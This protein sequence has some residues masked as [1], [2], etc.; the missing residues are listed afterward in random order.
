MLCRLVWRRGSRSDFKND[1]RHSSLTAVIIIVPPH[2]G[3]NRS[4]QIAESGDFVYCLYWSTCNKANG[5]S[6]VVDVARDVSYW[7]RKLNLFSR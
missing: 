4:T 6:F 1:L 2:R 3:K 5:A 7:T